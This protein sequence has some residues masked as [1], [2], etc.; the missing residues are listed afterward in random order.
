MPQKEGRGASQKSRRTPTTRC[1]ICSY[2]NHIR[3]AFCRNCGDLK[4]TPESG[5]FKNAKRSG[6]GI[7]PAKLKRAKQVQKHSERAA[8][9]CE[10][11]IRA[12][13][14]QHVDGMRPISLFMEMINSTFQRVMADGK[15][16]AAARKEAEKAFKSALRASAASK[17]DDD[18][19]GD[20]EEEDDEDEDEDEEE[21]EDDDEED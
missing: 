8:E 13:K 16:E 1:E 18:D 3:S 5:A 6:Y 2:R 9:V 12:N 19:D 15:G 10:A 21:E 17:D 14:P 11:W 20:E 7:V 4:G